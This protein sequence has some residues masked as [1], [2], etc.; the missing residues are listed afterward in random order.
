VDVERV[1][2]QDAA[3]LLRQSITYPTQGR[4]LIAAR[5]AAAG[6]QNGLADDPA[7]W[8][9]RWTPTQHPEC[10]CRGRSGGLLSS[11]T[12]QWSPG[13]RTQ[14]LAGSGLRPAPV[15]AVPRA[16]AKQIDRP[17]IEA[18]LGLKG[19]EVT[20]ARAGGTQ[21]RHPC[22]LTPLTAQLNTLQTGS[23]AW[24]PRD[25]PLIMDA[26]EQASLARRSWPRRSPRHAPDQPDRK[27]PWTI[28]V[29][30]LAAMLAVE[31]SRWAGSALP[32]GLNSQTLR[33][34]LT[35]LL[36]RCR[37]SRRTPALFQ[38]QDQQLDVMQNSITGRS[39]DVE[40]SLKAIQGK[41]Q[42]R[43][44]CH[45]RFRLKEPPASSKMSGEQLGIRELVR[46]ESTYFY[47]SNA[48]AS[49]YQGGRG[50]FHGLLVAPARPSRCPRAWGISAS[51]TA[52]PRP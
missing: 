30:T 9:W 52:T 2:H 38:R 4:I 23:Y 26:S 27:G 21:C 33:T 34:Y 31:R 51:I 50:P 39:L 13:R 18:S 20:V 42:G 16:A 46:A 22:T 44:R 40:A 3:V 19:A 48:A 5:P 14:R 32:G 35:Q 15:A 11:L 7:S 41:S 1:I 10:L 25:P 24:Y 12:E 36:P 45:A 28:D 43:T 6:G 49:R 37:S 8:A 47:G 29:P 17:I